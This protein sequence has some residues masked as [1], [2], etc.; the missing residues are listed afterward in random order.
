MPKRNLAWIVIVG[1]VA[2][3][4]WQLPQTI[5]GRDSVLKA[6]GPLVDARA[7]I[8]KRFAENVPDKRLVEAAVDSGIRAMVRKLNDPYAIYLNR[9]EY[10]QFKERTD[11]HYGGIGVDVWAAPM[12]LEVL[13][14]APDS[15]AMRA[16]ILPG[17]IITRINDISTKGMSLVDAVHHYLNGPKGTQVALTLVRP[18][19]SPPTGP[20]EIVVYR[21]VI[22]LES[23][24]GWS[25]SRSG[26][27]RFMLD[28]DSKIGYIRLVKFTPDVD[29]RMTEEINRMLRQGLRGLILDLRENTGGLLASAREVADRFLEGGQLIVRTQGRRTDEKRWFAMREGTF[30]MFPIAVLVNGSTASAAEIIAGGLRD[31]RRAVVFGERTYGKG[32]VQEVIE[33]QDNGGAIKMTTAHY[34]LPGGKCIH[35]TAQAER[36][37]TWG[38]V[39]NRLVNL[40]ETQ[41]VRWLNAWREISRETVSDGSGPTS[42]RQTTQPVPDDGDLI[43]SAA[44]K[45][46][47][48][49]I[50]LDAAWE[51]LKKI[52]KKNIPRQ[53]AAIHLPTVA[54]V[55]N[56]CELS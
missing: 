16:G 1:M 18:G 36:D 9:R 26:G 34:Y 40:N 2:L 5:A 6:F 21:A 11:G 49:D 27:W 56:R 23:V 10:K 17:D 42:N 48:E 20:R 45:L 44:Q 13:S 54:P 50:Q 53:T 39:P 7:Q 25:R 31:N 30:P 22:H 19:D 35:K 51:H 41:R 37:G 24:R 43:R 32:S 33:L 55:S 14:R 28:T 46:L 52:L 47:E 8:H 12:G 29:E 38:V 4:M 3:F 15:P